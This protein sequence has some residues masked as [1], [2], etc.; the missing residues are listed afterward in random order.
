MI[1]RC[2]HPCFLTSAPISHT[3]RQETRGAEQERCGAGAG[4]GTSSHTHNKQPLD[5]EQEEQSRGIDLAPSQ[6]RQR[7]IYSFFF[8]IFLSARLSFSGL[9]LERWRRF[10]FTLRASCRPGGRQRHKESPRRCSFCFRRSETAPVHRGA[11]HALASSHARASPR[12]FAFYLSP[13]S[14]AA[15]LPTTTHHPQRATPP[16]RAPLGSNV[17]SRGRR[18]LVAPWEFFSTGTR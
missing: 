4:A 1:S 11:P 8:K 9:F 14:F 15:P 16:L 7:H 6:P 18:L 13:P 10:S 2:P 12:A 17:P 3:Q 5:P